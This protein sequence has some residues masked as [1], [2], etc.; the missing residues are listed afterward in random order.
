M[1]VTIN[2]ISANRLDALADKLAEALQEGW[3]S[4]QLATELKSV[5]DDA[6]WADLVAQTE[7]TRAVS[8]S[9]LLTYQAQGVT[10]SIW[11]TAHDQRVCPICKDNDGLSRSIGQDFPSGDSQPPAHPR[12]RCA[13][14]PDLD[15]ITLQSVSAVL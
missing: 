14:G 8:W 13:L 9:T 7:L 1:G 6:N 11:L 15:S 5:L 3:S 2:S 12:C 10:K 4:D